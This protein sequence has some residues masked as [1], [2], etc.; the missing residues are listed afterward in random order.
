MGAKGLWLEFVGLEKSLN[1]V[2]YQLFNLHG[3]TKETYG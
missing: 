2:C 1:F 3:K